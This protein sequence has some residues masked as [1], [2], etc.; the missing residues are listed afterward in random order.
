MNLNARVPRATRV[1]QMSSKVVNK[2]A[3]SDL[4]FLD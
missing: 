4:R 1:I 3:V 2:F